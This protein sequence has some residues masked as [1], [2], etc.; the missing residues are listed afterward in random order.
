MVQ[1]KLVEFGFPL[2]AEIQ[3]FDI[4]KY[5]LSTSRLWAYD[6]RGGD[7]SAE[8]EKLLAAYGWDVECMLPLEI[9]HKDGSFATG[10]AAEMVILAVEDEAATA[11]ESLVFCS[12]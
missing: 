6:P 5:G 7:M 8:R 9:R 10:R 3:C 12:L 4:L 2:K 1:D 11:L